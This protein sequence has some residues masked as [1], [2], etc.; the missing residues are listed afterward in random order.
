MSYSISNVFAEATLPM[1]M[2]WVPFEMD[3]R[4]LRNRVKNKMIRPTTIPQSMQEL[5]FEQAI[6]KEAL[7]LA[8]VQHKN[9][10]TV[11]KGVQQQRT[12]ADAFEQSA[13][14]QTIVNMMTLDMLIGSGGVMSHAP[15]RQQSA[16]MLID[17]FLPEGVTRLAVDSIFMM[18]QLGVLTEVQPKAATEV[19]EKDCL[20]H[21][22]TCVAPAGRA[23][24]AGPIL[25][26]R[27]DLPDG[28]VSGTLDYLDMK[29]FKLGLQE[30]GLPM[31]T[32]AVLE[33]ERG[34]D[35]GGGPGNKIERELHGGVVG[36]V[37]DG[38]G[39]P[40]D[41]SSLSEQDRVKYLKK[42]MTELD[43]YPTGALDTV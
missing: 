40:F 6:A 16:L 31:K 24:K 13:S 10:A 4:D 26:Y 18:P 5:I 25:N 9:F 19:F 17:A 28:Q 32:R 20:I 42:W 27:I 12:I 8:L 35:V 23:K 21:L 43:I 3:E 11:L 41:L 14:G 34:F 7:R 1:V 38:R 39:R 29:Q 33:P 36:I 15:R 37:L 30:N 22:G 2:R